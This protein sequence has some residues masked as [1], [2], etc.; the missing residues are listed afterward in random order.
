[1]TT[2]T[3][4]ATK[5]LEDLLEA[6]GLEYVGQ[7]LLYIPGAVEKVLKA[8][9]DHDAADG[10]IRIPDGEIHEMIYDRDYA[11]DWADQLAVAIAP[12]EVLG[13]H[14]S[15]NHVW[16]NA[17][18]YAARVRSIRTPDSLKSVRETLCVAQSAMH[19][20]DR[21]NSAQIRKDHYDRIERLLEDID[22]QRPLGS[23]GKH[24]SLHT[25]TCGCEDIERDSR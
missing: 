16:F 3:Q 25:P 9:D 19:E 20:L 21:H 10:V 6:I 13:E 5:A 11:H 7:S 23:N 2:R 18:E 8:A 4:A 14:S 22:R 24:G 15:R 1:M 17:L 12:Y